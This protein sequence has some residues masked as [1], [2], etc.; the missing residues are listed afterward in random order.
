M[1]KINLGWLKDKNGE[2]FAPKTITTQVI[3]E[4]G[5]NLEDRLENYEKLLKEK[6]DLP[7]TAEV[8]QQLI[9]KAIDDN[10]RPTDWECIER[11]CAYLGDEFI[12]LLNE[13]VNFTEAHI[14]AVHSCHAILDDIV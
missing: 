7:L 14:Q 6:I 1:P 2:K 5:K 3:S 11:P 9:V 13:D 10:G 8:G 12:T 4:T